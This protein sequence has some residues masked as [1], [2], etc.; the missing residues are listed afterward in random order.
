VI[1][2][3]IDRKKELTFSEIVK[4]NCHEIYSSF[5]FKKKQIF[6]KQNTSNEIYQATKE[7]LRNINKESQKKTKLQNFFWTVFKKEVAKRNNFNPLINKNKKI[8]YLVDQ[9]LLEK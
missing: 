4:K 9:H 8:P 3:S 6:L 7:F 5:E 2:W 1:A